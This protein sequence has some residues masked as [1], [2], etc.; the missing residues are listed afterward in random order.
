MSTKSLAHLLRF[1]YFRFPFDTKKPIGYLGA[2]A[3]QYMQLVYEFF[4]LA[5]LITIGVGA[6]L[7]LMTTTK[8]IKYVLHLISLFAQAKRNRQRTIKQYKEF[9][10]EITLVKQ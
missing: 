5:N 2:V 9:V 1:A 6:F 10:E 3:L 8:D 4:L 7:Y